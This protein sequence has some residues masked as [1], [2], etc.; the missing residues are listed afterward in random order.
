MDFNIL[1]LFSKSLDTKID[2]LENVLSEVNPSGF[3][4]NDNNSEV[5][6]I[7]YDI[8]TIGNLRRQDTM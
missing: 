2:D 6:V 3:T 5:Q 7:D 1:W 4:K 8:D